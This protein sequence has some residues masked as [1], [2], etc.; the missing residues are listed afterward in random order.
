MTDRPEP[1][2]PAPDNN[3]A[4]SGALTNGAAEPVGHI[5][6]NLLRFAEMLRR[7]GLDVGS[8]NVLDLV[9]GMDYVQIGRRGEFYQAARS[10]FVHRKQDIPIFDEAFQVFWRKPAT[11]STDMDLRTLGEQRRT[12]TQMNAGSDAEPDDPPTHGREADDEPEN[13][14][15]LNRTYSSREVL[16]Q[17]DFAEFTGREMAEARGM[18]A[19]LTWDLGQRRTRRMA[20]GGGNYLDLRRTMRNSLKFGGEFFELA[21]R[22]PKDKPRSLVLICDVSGSMERY[23]RMLLHFMHTVASGLDRLEAF[24]FATRLTRITRHLRYRSV[25][26]A[27]NEV[28][29]AVPDWAGGTRI[30]DAIKTFNYQWLRRVMRG[31][32]IVLIISDGW[33]RGE[34]ELLAKETSRLQRSCHRLIWLN[35]LLGSPGYQPLTRGM[36]AALPY[37]DDFLPVHN[38][39][40]LEAL[41]QHLSALPPERGTPGRYRPS[42]V[43][44]PEPPTAEPSTAASSPEDR[45]IDRIDRPAFRQPPP[46]NGR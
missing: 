18:M 21:T 5:L 31:Q 9:R 6:P 16:R 11:G 46:G 14:V 36:Q 8:G 22:A 41:A 2:N 29:Q 37:I 33:D 19:H 7:L 39:T 20:P 42:H 44:E 12:R 3:G 38:L 28:S 30:G 25:D 24:L 43:G 32:A 27:I 23:T 4:G 13:Q 35:P 40:S 10:I 45:P 17:K 1:I 26:Q 34:P 15:D